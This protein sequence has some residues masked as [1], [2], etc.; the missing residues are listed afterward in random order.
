MYALIHFYE[1]LLHGNESQSIFTPL[2]G[3]ILQ[4]FVFSMGILFQS[5]VLNNFLTVPMDLNL[6]FKVLSDALFHYQ[7][8]ICNVKLKIT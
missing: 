8:K 4:G 3:T 2:F 5:L 6:Y 7:S 1:H